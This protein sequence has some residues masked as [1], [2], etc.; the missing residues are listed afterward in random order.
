LVGVRISP[1]RN[2][3]V[4]L[5]DSLALARE[6]SQGGWVDFLHLSC[7]DIRQTSVQNTSG[8]RVELPL[9][10]WF[11]QQVPNLPPVIT[12]GSVWTLED[13][14]LGLGMGA[15][16][17]GSGRSAIGNWDWAARICEADDAELANEKGHG[18]K[19]GNYSFGNYRE[20]QNYTGAY[21]PCFPPYSEEHLTACGLSPV[22]IYYMRRW[23]F[24]K[25]ANGRILPFKD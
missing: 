18:E 2:C 3:G 19:V 25:D 21:Q 22:F 8:Q 11:T 12:T 10:Q 1:E 14:K 23:K 13:C 20:P 7:W 9:T 5:E 17:I 16:L 24:V 4:R 6:L 15:D